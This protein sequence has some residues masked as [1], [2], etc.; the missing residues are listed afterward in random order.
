M[1][2][3]RKADRRPERLAIP[4]GWHPSGDT[5]GMR[6]VASRAGMVCPSSQSSTGQV[7]TAAYSEVAVVSVTCQSR[8]TLV[9]D[10][11][12]YRDAAVAEHVRRE[13]EVPH[14]KSDAVVLAARQS[15][16]QT[17]SPDA[18]WDAETRHRLSA[19]DDH[20]QTCLHGAALC[21]GTACSQYHVHFA[22]YCP[23]CDDDETDCE[24]DEGDDLLV[25]AVRGSST[26][27]RWP[28]S[29]A[30]CSACA[31]GTG[32]GQGFGSAE[33]DSGT[34][35]S[36]SGPGTAVGGRHGRGWGRHGSYRWVG[37]P[38]S[39]GT[40]GCCS[41][42]RVLPGEGSRLVLGRATECPQAHP[43]THQTL[44]SCEMPGRY[45]ETCCW[46]SEEEKVVSCD[47]GRGSSATGFLYMSE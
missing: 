46:V 30:A 47:A 20:R 41:L 16:L 10:Q 24:R 1:E 43:S 2:A 40:G 22:S 31:E 34:G 21:D 26:A 45:L 7:D 33:P 25:A 29:P 3:P 38:C 37:S 27:G 23:T 28:A 12:F 14:Q 5:S 11:S 19:H 32:R 44:V 39:A 4:E 9:A 8:L 13:R 36:V 6:R 17:E 35:S 18:C 42:C 15:T